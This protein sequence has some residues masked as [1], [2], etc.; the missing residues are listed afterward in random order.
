[1]F[2]IGAAGLYGSYSLTYSSSAIAKAL[3]VEVDLVYGVLASMMLLSFLIGALGLAAFVTLL[4][5]VAAESLG[6]GGFAARMRGR[7]RPRSDKVP[8]E[9]AVEGPARPDDN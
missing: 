4:V 1:M 9:P 2:V 8:G 5:T 7:L 6:R 3:S